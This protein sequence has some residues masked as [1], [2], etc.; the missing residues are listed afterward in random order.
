MPQR[1]SSF[2]CFCS[3][4]VALTSLAAVGCGGPVVEVDAAVAD[5]SSAPDGG[6]DAFVPIPDSCDMGELTAV[7]GVMGET[8]SVDFD[9]TMTTTRPRDLGLRCGNPSGEVRWAEQEVVEFHVPGTAPV[10]VR[11]SAVNDGTA[12]DFDTVIQVRRGDCRE[13]PVDSFPP[14]CFN[15]ATATEVRSGGGVQAMGGDT[16]YFIITGYSEPPASEMTVD[17][18]AIHVEFTVEA[19]TAPT[20]TDA[21]VTLA[22]AETL[23]NVVAT[24]AEGPIVG[25]VLS[26]YAGARRLDIFG[27]GVADDNDILTLAFESVDRVGTTYTGTDIIRS[28]TEYTIAGYCRAVGCTQLGIRVFDSGYA[29]STELRVDV[30]EALIS[31]FGEVCDSRHLCGSGLV[32]SAG[33]CTATSAATSL[34][35]VAPVLGVPTPT[36]TATSQRVTG[37]ITS[38]TGNFNGSCGATPG[39]DALWRF[40][41]PPGRFDVRLTTDVAGT[42]AATNTVL[43]LRS[44]C[45][46]GRTEV[47]C[48]DDLSGSAIHSAISLTEPAPGDY[49][50]FVEV[51]GGAMATTGYG[52]SA[53]LVPVLDPGVACDPAA[54]ANRCG[55]GVCPAGASP[56]CP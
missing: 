46:D 5:A 52:L 42:G 43:Y 48:N 3:C 49:T 18:G 31:D 16:L 45:I 6:T 36:T 20:L 12:I 21:S 14:S 38:G 9:T 30:E 37:T 56:V 11:V 40:T 51:S 50:I 33:T 53:T 29:G 54:L 10:G 39:R 55:T 13:V 26:F 22:N 32:C 15:D 7:D 25:Y 17:A 47:V 4:L 35:G 44:T 34:C 1:L 2:A 28:M 27:D 8:V 24:D 41:V 23:I 19:N